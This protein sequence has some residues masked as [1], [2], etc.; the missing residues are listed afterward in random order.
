MWGEEFSPGGQAAVEQV[1][2]GGWQSLS[3]EVFPTRVG[4]ALSNLI[5]IQHWSCFQQEIEL[6]PPF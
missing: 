4:K 3:L 6:E 1:A 5:W 2:Q